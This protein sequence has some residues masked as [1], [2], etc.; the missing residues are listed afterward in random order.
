MSMN[1]D[2][3]P[4]MFLDQDPLE[5]PPSISPSDAKKRPRSLLHGELLSEVKDDSSEPASPTVRKAQR[6]AH[7]IIDSPASSN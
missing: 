1:I 3:V 6:V 2:S 4:K 5:L 7:A